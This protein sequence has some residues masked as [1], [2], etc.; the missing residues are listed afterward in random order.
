MK[1]HRYPFIFS[2]TSLWS[3]CAWLLPYF[4]SK[5]RRGSAFRSASSCR[6]RSYLLVIGHQRDPKLIESCYAYYVRPLPPPSNAVRIWRRARFGVNRWLEHLWGRVLHKRRK[7]CY[8]VYQHTWS[9]SCLIEMLSQNNC[10]I[11]WYIWLV[12]FFFLQRWDTLI[13]PHIHSGHEN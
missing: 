4:Q 12:S 1:T 9:I 8:T 5:V 10:C 2:K 11:N 6:S 13:K 7:C 3:S